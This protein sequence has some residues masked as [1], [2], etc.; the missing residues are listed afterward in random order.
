[1]QLISLDLTN[2]RQHRDTR[3]DFLPGVTG[4]IGKNGSGKSTVLEAMA[5][6]LYGSAALRGKNETVRCKS[7]EGNAPAEV[8]LAFGLGA[9]E[10]RVTRRLEAS[11]RTSA[12]LLID[13][14]SARTGFKEVTESITKLLGMDYQ[15]FF[16]SFFTA[17]KE[18]D[19]MRGM[20]GRQRAAAVTRMLGYERLVR[21]REKANQDRLGLQHQIDGLERGLGDPE[22]IKRRKFDA[23]SAKAESEKVLK[24]VTKREDAAKAEVVRLKPLRELSE[25]KAKRAAEL[26]RRLELDTAEETRAASRVKELSAEIEDL[27]E[28]AKELESLAPQLEE[29]KKAGEEYRVLA[30][31]QKHE[32]RRAAIQ[33]QLSAT[34]K[35]LETLKKRIDKLSG[36]PGDIEKIDKESSGL[37]KQLSEVDARIERERNA[38]ASARQ[39]AELEMEQAAAQKDEIAAK[40]RTIEEAGLSGKCPTCE[41][42]LAEELPKVLAGFDDQISKLGSRIEKLRTAIAGLEAEPETLSGLLTLKKAL[43][44][45]RD[46]KYGERTEVASK[47][48]EMDGCIREQKSKSETVSALK[49][50][51]EKLPSGFDQEK[52]E[53]LRSIGERL[54][55]VRDRSLEL[56]TALNRRDNIEADLK[57]EGEALSRVKSELEATRTA[58]S[59][60]NFSQ[61]EHEKLVLLFE[62]AVSASNAV[63]IETERAKGDLKAAQTALTAAETDEKAYKVK[64]AELGSKRRER[65]ELQTLAEAFDNLR[66]DLNNRAAPELAAAASDLLSEM[67]DGRYTSLEVN[68]DYEAMIRDDGELKPIISGGEEDIVNLA[69]RLAV[70]RMI[71]DR[72]GQDLSLLV[73]DEVF[74]SLDDIRRDNVVALLQV[75]KCRFEQIILITHVESIHD[76]VDNCIWVD[77]DEISR[78]SKIR[79]A[80]SSDEEHISTDACSLKSFG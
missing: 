26:S 49:S 11:G 52:F 75:L 54:K 77:Y 67:T 22:E 15:A 48:S 20:D 17:Q 19:F 74:G 79:I 73:L 32:S 50:E 53:M 37:A 39:R 69:L 43:E 71:A 40:K 28:K 60:L 35:D 51:I 66:V 68:E 36:T 61:K 3:L 41:R 21:A 12:N 5:W 64:E 7:A 57:R 23:E 56:K 29:Y 65:A 1:M 55:P 45:E 76:S 34:E 72:A 59:E 80:S 58:S 6:A 47:K 42:P 24:A 78:T 2:F 14:V 33:G 27:S 13:G 38:L 18:I 8:A 44:R 9:H 70:S 10:Y 4:I 46:A 16:T 30:E 31:L 25:E 63:S 62:G